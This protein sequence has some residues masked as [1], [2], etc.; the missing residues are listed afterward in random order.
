MIIGTEEKDKKLVGALSETITLIKTLM[1][2][3]AEGK[4]ERTKT[5]IQDSFIDTVKRAVKG[6]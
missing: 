5:I 4:D 6:E 3:L 2:L 1:D